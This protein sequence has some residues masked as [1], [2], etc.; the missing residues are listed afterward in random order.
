[1]A[2]YKKLTEILDCL[3]TSP[4]VAETA[5]RCSM[6]PQTIW[7]YLLRSRRG[8]PLFQE[9]TWHN[10]TCPWHQHFENSKV[11]AAAAIEQAALDRAANGCL[12]PS[13]YMG[14]PVWQESESYARIGFK[15]DDEARALGFN[16]EVDRWEW[17][18]GPEGKPRRKQVMTWLKP[19]SQL[20]VKMLESWHKRYRPHQQLDVNYGGVL[21]LERADERSPKTIEE[22]PLFDQQGDV[23]QRGGHLALGRPAKDSAEMDKWDAAGEFKPAPVT[24][25]DAEGNRI[26]RVAAP[27]PLLSQPQASASIGRAGN[28][29][30]KPVNSSTLET[31]DLPADGAGPLRSRPLPGG[32]RVR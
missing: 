3:V 2:H 18:T 12:V 4:S 8:D 29:P 15:N 24:F 28:K 17:E 22:K 27:D 5:R 1:M 31:R 6:T 9:V 32:Y 13:F 16:P 25:V 21:R 23:E 7:S 19:D 20:V 11:L 30:E 26:E 10:I 14:A